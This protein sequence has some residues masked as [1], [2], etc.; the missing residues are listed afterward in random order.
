MAWSKTFERVW[1]RAKSTLPLVTEMSTSSKAYS[2]RSDPPFSRQ[3][4]SMLRGAA[5]INQDESCC[6][7]GTSHF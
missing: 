7:P 4:L 6:E 2:A 3:S 5:G 1:L